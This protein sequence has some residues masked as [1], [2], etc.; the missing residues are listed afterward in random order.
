MFN[1]LEHWTVNTEPPFSPW[2][3]KKNRIEK[4][5]EKTKLV[6]CI[7]Y[8]INCLLSRALIHCFCRVNTHEVRSKFVACCLCDGV[9]VCAFGSFH[10]HLI[11]LISLFCIIYSVTNCHFIQKMFHQFKR[12]KRRRQIYIFFIL[13]SFAS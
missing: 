5:N 12:H 6:T 11:P 8:Y 13:P 4:R 3:Q 1:K 2:Y 7:L 9:C 10:S